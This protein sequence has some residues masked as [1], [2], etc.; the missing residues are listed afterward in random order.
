MLENVTTLR[1]QEPT[2]RTILHN[3]MYSSHLNEARFYF[4]FFLLVN[5][6]IKIVGNGFLLLVI[7]KDPLKIFRTPPTVFI[8]SLS[9]TGFCAGITYEPILATMGM[10]QNYNNMLRMVAISTA[11]I[12]WKNSILIVF[13]F[14]VAQLVAVVSPLKYARKITST[15]IVI[16]NVI[17][18]CYSITTRAI[19]HHT[20]SLAKQFSL[21]FHFIL[22]PFTTLAVYISLYRAF[23]RQVS[24][25]I[26][27]GCETA[28][29]FESR[30]RRRI[31][32]QQY[33]TINLILILTTIVGTQATVIPAFLYDLHTFEAPKIVV[34]FALSTAGFLSLKLVSDT[35][36]F[37]WR[38]PQ[39][40][41]ALRAL[42]L[43]RNISES[44]SNNKLV[45]IRSFKMISDGVLNSN[46]S[47]S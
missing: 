11:V 45:T 15:K 25:N 8:A 9:M 7:Y 18:L 44:S 3:Q 23:K 2:N 27:L 38:F 6:L 12:L 42:L 32:Q 13:A 17:I 41:K 4:A 5:A 29:Q 35:I 21:F 47:I 20:S 10:L 37:A 36:I 46:V 22:I 33:M 43:N 28:K 1:P 39:Y 30:N 34:Y 31:C 40:R 14:T 26:S 24:Q 19:F 16:A